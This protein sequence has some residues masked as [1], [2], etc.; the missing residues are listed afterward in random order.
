MS[1]NNKLELALKA[2]FTSE[3]LSKMISEQLESLSG[4]PNGTTFAHRVSGNPVCLD[5]SS[6]LLHD[7][8]R[9][10]EL[11]MGQ[12]TREQSILQMDVAVNGIGYCLT[13]TGP[14]T[15]EGPSWTVVVRDNIDSTAQRPIAA[16]TNVR[17]A[18]F[19]GSWPQDRM[20]N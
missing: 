9:L 1:D 17:L 19:R 5:D 14:P 11:V 12:C 20:R 10:L 18:D 7:G 6:K 13:M 3:P 8:A 2:A 16:V 15:T 4:N